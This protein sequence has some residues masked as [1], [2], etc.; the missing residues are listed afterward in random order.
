[1]KCPHCE[2]GIFI[3]PSGKGVKRTHLGLDD[4]M[5]HWYLEY[6]CC[7]ACRQYIVY[8]MTDFGFGIKDRQLIYPRNNPCSKCPKEVPRGIAREYTE[9]CLILP[10]SSTASAAMSRRCLQHF[11]REV[12]KVKAKRNSL[13]DEI[14][15]VISDGTL[16]SYI[17]KDL[18]TVR[19]IGNFAAHPIKSNQTGTILPV[20]PG[21]AEWNLKVLEALFDFCCVKP[22][23]AKKRKDALNQKLIEAGTPPIP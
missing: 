16:P 13:A 2:A 5:V 9:A 14:K 10:I 8:I 22:A 7:P 17:S 4:D 6:I 3:E 21:E 23:E 20:E 11:M 15:Q 19:L 18:D 12:I 1:M